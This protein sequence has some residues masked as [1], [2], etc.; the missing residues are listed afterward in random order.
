MRTRK[1]DF[2]AGCPLNQAPFV[3]RRGGNETTSFEGLGDDGFG[4]RDGVM[5]LKG[6]GWVEERGSSRDNAGH[7]VLLFVKTD[8]RIAEPYTVR[9]ERRN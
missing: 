4:G 7:F 5:G 2:G 3:P 1:V 8:P 6:S 9:Y